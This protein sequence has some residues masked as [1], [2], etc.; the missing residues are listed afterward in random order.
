MVVIAP[1]HAT[2]PSSTLTTE[3]EQENFIPVPQDL[4]NVVTARAVLCVIVTAGAFK[5]NGSKPVG[6]FSAC[7]VNSFSI[8]AYVMSTSEALET[9]LKTFLTCTSLVRT[10]GFD[11]SVPVHRQAV[12]L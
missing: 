10:G 2:T 6:H 8:S 4:V 5:F 7:C 3:F 9:A 12:H 1:L 11:H